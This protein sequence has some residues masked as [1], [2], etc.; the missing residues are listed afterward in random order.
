[1]SQYAVLSL[2]RPEQRFDTRS[3]RRNQN[4]IRHQFNSKL[5]PVSQVVIIALLLCVLGVIYLMQVTKT[6]SYGYQ[7]NDLKQQQEELLTQQSELKIENARLQALERVKQSKVAEAM[8]APVKT[9]YV[10]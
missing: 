4:T 2:Q 6:S 7:I 3:W 8:T 9:D 1:M 10:Q 5:G